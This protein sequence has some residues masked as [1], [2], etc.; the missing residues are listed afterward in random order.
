MTSSSAAADPDEKVDPAV[1]YAMNLWPCAPILAQFLRCNR[2]E[3]CAKTV[4]ELGAGATALP[5]ITAAKSGASHVIFTDQS[6][7]EDALELCRQNCLANQIEEPDVRGLDWGQV[8]E[9]LTNLPRI[10]IILASDCFF[11]PSVFEDLIMTIAW[12]MEQNTDCVCYFSYQ[13]RNPDWN[14][15]ISDLLEKWDLRWAPID[16]NSFPMHCIDIPGFNEELRRH[17]VHV[18]KITALV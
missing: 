2:Q 1:P 9:K 12:L 10:D 8:D 17:T 3:L 15:Y 18:G 5:G 4:L 14:I 7:R 6:D 13:E 16:P 11:D